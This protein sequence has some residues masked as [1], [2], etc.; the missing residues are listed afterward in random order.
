MHTQHNLETFNTLLTEQYTE[1]FTTPEYSIVAK[2]FTPSEFARNMTLGLD[3]GTAS[4][5]G[6]G[7]INVCKALGIK[8]T[9]KAIREYLTTE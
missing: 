8:H 2:N 1:L 3:Q 4:K 5:D 7:I 9:Y 6:K